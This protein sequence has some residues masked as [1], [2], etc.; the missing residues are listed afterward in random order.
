MDPNA[1]SG[2]RPP[3]LDLPDVK[4]AIAACFARIIIIDT[5]LRRMASRARIYFEASMSLENFITK[6]DAELRDLR[7]R[8]E[9]AYGQEKGGITRKINELEA[10][11]L[12]ATRKGVDR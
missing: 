10:Y 8:R 11:R 9:K 1:S 2:A 7:A 12:R 6:I 3:R 5:D 4:F